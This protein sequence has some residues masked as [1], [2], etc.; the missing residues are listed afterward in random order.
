[1]SRRAV[2]AFP[3]VPRW[4]IGIY[5]G[6]SPIALAPLPGVANPVLTAA[7][8]TDVPAGFVADPFLLPRDGRWHLF[9]EV[10][11]RQSGR[12][13]I[14]LATSPD[15]RGWTYE[16]VVLREP[17]HLSFPHV[18]SFDDDVFMLPETLRAGAVRL[19]RA[20]GFPHRWELAGELVRGDFADPAL[21]RWEERWWLFVCSAPYRHDELRLY[22]ADELAG[23]WREHPRSPLVAGDP[24]RARPAGR[25]LSWEGRLLRFAQDCHP[26]YGTGVRAF[27]ILALDPHE[28]RESEVD[29][30]PLL[31]PSGAGWNGTG[32]H[33]LD[34]HPDGTGGWLAAVDGRHGR[35]RLKVPAVPA[36]P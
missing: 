23:P 10:L 4:S 2:P 35:R 20:T 26:L 24:R 12:G 15:G 22:C 7:D 3:G 13:E 34:A 27:E 11:N 6:S 17:F 5:A 18:F 16:R 28:Y 21:L 36:V 31:I 19:Y 29:E 1:V 25:I 14:A 9:C 8:V 32:M 33:H 30:S